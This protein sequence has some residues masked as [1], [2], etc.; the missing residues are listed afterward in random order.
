MI[1]YN[2]ET[3]QLD[4]KMSL[5]F[6]NDEAKKRYALCTYKQTHVFV[7]GG[8]SLEAD[9]RYSV[10]YFLTAVLKKKEDSSE[11]V[12]EEDEDT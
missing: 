9:A 8:V 11:A 3:N 5:S 2:P 1:R 10:N 7:I 12:H 4:D 6:P